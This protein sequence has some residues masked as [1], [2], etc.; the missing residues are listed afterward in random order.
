MQKISLILGLIL[1]ITLVA[2]KED[3]QSPNN[4]VNSSEEE[5][6]ILEALDKSDEVYEEVDDA[7]DS[8]YDDGNPNWGATSLEKSGLRVHF[9]RRV[10]K[11]EG[12]VEVVLT[13][14]TTATVYIERIFTGK[15]VSKTGEQVNDSTFSMQKFEKPLHH[16]VDRIVYM[17]K[18][19]EDAQVERRNWKV[20]SISLADG[21][22]VPSSVTITEVALY[23][24]NQP[25][26]V[27]SEPTKYFLNGVNM[28]TFPRHTEIKVVVKVANNTVN[29]VEWPQGSGATEHARV[30]FGRNR[31]GHVA[32]T[33]LKFKGTE[34][35]L[36]IYEGIWT[37]QQ[38]K[39]MHHA[40][41]D[42]ID[43]GTILK[44]DDANYPYSSA[45]WGTPYRVTPF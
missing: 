38:L 44:S 17:R 21:I 32:K 29:P 19:R 12:K 27:I 30:H 4:G 9:G 36:N 10:T 5:A 15:L 24:E 1:L 8:N 2:C 18:F 45:T 37:V 43:N 33:V 28:F 39:G 13:S 7:D 26:V 35:G 14:D 3:S 25:A 23:P 34:N 16:E 11:R 6:L 41:I 22:S 42:V 31:K 40:I 20:E